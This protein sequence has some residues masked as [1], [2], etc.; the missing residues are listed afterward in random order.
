MPWWGVLEKG[1]GD[2]KFIARGKGGHASA[3]GKNTPL[4][5]LGKFMADVEKHDP[6]TSEFNPT[7]LEMFRRVT[8]NM[9]FGMKMVFANLWLF[10]PLLKKLMPSISPAGAAMLH[11]TIAFTMAKG[12][13]TA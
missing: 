12:G 3:P 13:R 8:P 7:V 11:T 5:R 9:N 10:K 2:L 6:F 4:V 1:Y